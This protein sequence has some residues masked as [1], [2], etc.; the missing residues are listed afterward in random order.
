MVKWLSTEK[1]RY[2][3]ATY[4]TKPSITQ[5]KVHT[6]IHNTCT[7]VALH[8]MTHY[9]PCSLRRWSVTQPLCVCSPI[10]LLFFCSFPLSAN[11]SKL[12][13]IWFYCIVI[14]VL[15]GI[16]CVSGYLSCIHNTPL[17]NQISNTISTFIIETAW[18]LNGVDPVF[19][20][21]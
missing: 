20:L 3:S 16:G 21:D 4:L 1:F 19:S 13:Y 9:I 14:C 8:S 7:Q 5:F 12:V 15:V 6:R 18:W 11:S 2:F 10:V 17:R